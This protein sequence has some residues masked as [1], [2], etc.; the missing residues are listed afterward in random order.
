MDLDLGY[1]G[2]ETLHKNVRLPKKSSK[3]HPL[4]EKEKHYNKRVAKS[5]VLVEHVIRKVKVF[6][7]MAERYRNRRK[8]H[9]LRMQL[10]CAIYNLELSK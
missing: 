2:M 1:W 4:T 7:I 5:R 10:I 3:L 8:R 9:S 6:R